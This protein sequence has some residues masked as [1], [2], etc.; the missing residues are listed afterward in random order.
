MQQKL[1]GDAENMGLYH[2]KES[3]LPAVPQPM[4]EITVLKKQHL[5]KF[6][7][8]AEDRFDCIIF[9]QVSQI[10]LSLNKTGQ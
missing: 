6:H 3:N 4:G 9:T 7:I 8:S 1:M 5:H 10:S 2:L